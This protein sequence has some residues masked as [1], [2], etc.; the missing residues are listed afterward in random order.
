MTILARLVATIVCCTTGSLAQLAAAQ[1]YPNQ[2]V[3]IVVSAGAGSQPD[4]LGRMAAEGLSNKYGKPVVVETKPGANGIIAA[5]SVKNAKPDGY[6]LLIAD[7]AVTAIN[8]SIYAKLPYD[9]QK[10]FAP[11]TELVVQPF[12]VFA[13]VGLGANSIK[14]LIALLKAKPGQLNYGSAG[15]GSLHH[16]CSELLLQIVG[17]KAQHIQYKTGGEISRALIGDDLQFACSG[18]SGIQ[19]VNAGKAKVLLVSTKE[20]TPLVPNVPT[21][22][23]ETGLDGFEVVAR[24]GILAPTGTPRGVVEKLSDD[25][26][27]VYR[28]TKLRATLAS[29]NCEVVTA[30]P[31]AYASV[32]RREIDDYA[33][34]VKV[35]GITPQ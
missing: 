3:R 5:E 24:I 23:Q 19:M 28:D 4:I 32:I 26:R 17:A 8:K 9:P 15:L 7:N 29:Q 18:L 2:A 25:V 14:D 22:K 13:H 20:P 1:P 6:T 31:D 30:G 35:A 21:L 11:V 34:I 27:E 16:L 33:K 12:L 10:D